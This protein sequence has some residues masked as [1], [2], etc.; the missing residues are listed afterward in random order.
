M[1]GTL[2]VYT[3]GG[4]RGNPGPAA[5]GVYIQGGSGKE[6]ARIAKTIGTTTNNIAEYTAIVEALS[7]LTENPEVVQKAASVHVYV[8]S[9]LASSQLNGLYKVKNAK[10]AQLI[11]T[12]RTLEA[13][14]SK[15]VYYAHVRR[16]QNTVADSLV[17]LALDNNF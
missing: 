14:I 4:A 1:E 2:T 11:L 12:I 6:L 16:E 7:W 8:D 9:Q 3:D 10:L 15:P 5:I 13:G 17:N